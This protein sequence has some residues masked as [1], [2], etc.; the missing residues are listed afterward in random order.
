MITQLG[1]EVVKEVAIDG[2][3]K[4]WMVIMNKDSFT[5]LIAKAVLNSLKKVMIRSSL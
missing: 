5:P 2:K 1:A 3:E 4:I